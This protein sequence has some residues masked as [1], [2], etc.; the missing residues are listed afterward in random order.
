MDE[1]FRINALVKRNNQMAKK[2]IEVM[3][4]SPDLSIFFAFG[5]A[6]FRGPDNIVELVRKEGYRVLRL[7]VAD[8]MEPSVRS[9]ATT[10]YSSPVDVIVFLA[11]TIMVFVMTAMIVM[12]LTLVMFCCRWLLSGC[13]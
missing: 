7:K 5:A 10:W 2:S 3:E 13:C 11:F 6:H 1:Y 8:K 12:I 9:N 4:K